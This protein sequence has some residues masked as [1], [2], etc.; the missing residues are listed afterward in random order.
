[1]EWVFEELERYDIK[2]S[3]SG[4]NEINNEEK[5]ELSEIIKRRANE[6]CMEWNCET[7]EDE[8]MSIED[9]VEFGDIEVEG[10]YYEIKDENERSKSDEVILESQ[11]NVINKKL[12]DKPKYIFK[13]DK[14]EY[15]IKD[16]SK[17]NLK[18]D[19]KIKNTNVPLFDFRKK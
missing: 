15:E 14:R 3:Y 2:P 11:S 7:V 9:D 5:C 6:I 19:N 13:K 4:G 1:M 8:S 17:I 16:T 12:N 18:Q 10:D